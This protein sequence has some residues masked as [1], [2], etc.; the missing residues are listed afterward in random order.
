M[1]DSERSGTFSGLRGGRRRLFGCIFLLLAVLVVVGVLVW[2]DSQHI[3]EPQPGEP[4]PVE[5]PPEAVPPRPV[6]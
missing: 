2:I 6:Q 1:T 5:V 3:P 4:A